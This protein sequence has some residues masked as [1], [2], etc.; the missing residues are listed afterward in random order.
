MSATPDRAD[1]AAKDSATAESAAV[2]PTAVDP[3]AVDPTAVDPTAVDPTAADPTTVD[4]S[5][6][7]RSAVRAPHRSPSGAV[8]W[9]WIRLRTAPT[10]AAALALL[11]LALSLLAAAVPRA[12]DRYG[13]T[14]L[15]RE[16]SERGPLVR[17][18]DATAAPGAAQNLD[19]GQIGQAISPSQLAAV[20]RTLRA[21]AGPP[22]RIDPA[23]VS[24]GVSTTSPHLTLR[25]PG[26]PVIDGP[27]PVITL[28]WQQD[29]AAHVRVIAGRRP[30][31][32]A[33]T[34][35]A[36]TPTVMVEAMVGQATADLL[37]VHP[38][39][40]LHA[41]AGQETPLL[42]RITGVYSARSA[43]DPYWSFQ[44]TLL[45]PDRES[46]PPPDRT[47]YWHVEVLV[48]DQAPAVLP[49]L[50]P[51]DIYWHH[52]LL[53]GGL[54]AHRVAEAQQRLRDLV[55]GQTGSELADS[56][57][58]PGGVAV[59]SPLESL[60]AAFEQ[61]RGALA[62]L[63]AVAGAGLAGVAVAVLLTAAAL[64]A[65]RRSM[66]LSL[67]RAR[68]A[69]LSTLMGL[70]AAET[71]AVAV[72]AGAAGCGLALLLLPTGRAAVAVAAAAAATALVVLTVPLYAVLRHRRA[73]PGGARRDP[74]WAP[75]TRRRTVVDLAVLVA[76]AAAVAALRGRGVVGGT[77][78]DPLI[79]SAPP[80]LGLAGARL[81]ARVQPWLL[82]L[83]ARAAARGRGAVAF[84]GLTRGDRSAGPAAL[85]AMLL[86]LTVAVFGATVLDG[87][88]A[89][90]AAAALA[91]VGADARVES[92]AELPPVLDQEIRA[93]PGAHSAVQVR[94]Q[95]GLTFSLAGT[96]STEFALVVVDPATYA[97]LSATTGIGR[98]DP[99]L[100]APGRDSEAGVPAL[101]S[102]DI[103]GILSGGGGGGGA[104][105]RLGSLYGT[106]GLRYAGTIGD[107]P[108]VHRGE[109]FLVVPLTAVRTE[110][111]HSTS[112]AFPGPDL[113]LLT[114]AVDGAALRRAVDRAVQQ[115]PGTEPVAVSVR[116]EVRTALERA[117]QQQGA[118]ALYLAA[119]VAAAL[120]SVVAVLLSLARTSPERSALLVGLRT[121][122]M[123][124]RQRRL[125]VLL[126]TLPQVL[127]AALAGTLLG[128]AAGPV[129][130]PA[131]DL[132][133]LAG[134]AAPT[135]LRIHAGAVLLPAAGLLAAAVAAL[136]AEI[137]VT[138][139]RRVAAQLRAGGE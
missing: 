27:P 2:D 17:S 131:L 98:F 87:V 97:R 90:R 108:A 76:A 115:T 104:P 74:S 12:V 81:L 26:L 86:A 6:V 65:D 130:G 30:Q 51:V 138:G 129:L 24:Y 69:A 56:S 89:G 80:L 57:A 103:A 35:S 136:A 118:T 4:R 126:E 61:E 10:A 31:A 85:L 40:V 38:G 107:T 21:A 111:A 15:R 8:S 11:V 28:D 79:S 127:L 36:G 132:A 9:V 121:L 73:A 19:A 44:Q 22:L 47:R 18:I 110:W 95:R 52:P 32:A 99:A 63:L 58:I 128:V 43:A 94:V 50:G 42:V 60:L 109:Q 123:T 96:E 83:P 93:L 120:L 114:G 133:E 124:S 70:L 72:P 55:S 59:S 41:R 68:G 135:A 88:A 67:L 139:R 23:A 45:Q 46:T 116:S 16:L 20:E 78:V 100:L 71:A 117:P 105:P 25:D 14:A 13:D 66:E 34:G 92:D 101:A 5:T 82:R 48:G 1:P 137:A 75:P 122:G 106:F 84:L 91:K 134:T 53:P 77:G 64:N 33:F 39:S 112:A 102:P 125:L 54:P 113:N 37:G 3:T 119:V 29:Q 49:F 62:S 7:D